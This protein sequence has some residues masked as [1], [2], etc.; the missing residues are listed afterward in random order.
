MKKFF[1]TLTVV[2]LLA[3]GVSLF[4]YL[5]AKEKKPPVV[6]ETVEPFIT[7]IVKKTVA[8][9]SIKPRKEVEI[10]P[11]VPGILQEVYVEPGQMVKKDDPIAKVQIIPEMKELNAAEARLVQAKIKYDH[12]KWNIGQQKETFKEG[13]TTEQ[14]Y[15]RS[16]AEYKNAKAEYEAAE[17]NLEII[18]RG[19]AKNTTTTNTLICSTMDGM[20]LDVPVEKGDTVIQSNSFNAGSTIATVADMNDLIFEGKLDESE[21]GKIKIGMK[22]LISIGAIDNVEF[23]ATLEHI[24]P[25]GVEENGAILFPVRADVDLVD[26]IFVRAGYSATANIVLDKKEHVL[27]VNESVLQFDKD[28]KTFVEVEIAPQQYEKRYIETGISDSI[29]IEVI[30]GI[31]KDIKLK[32]PKV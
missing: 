15:H 30:S 27:A 4:V 7:D 22:L 9:G 5:A 13:I 3:G 28:N 21:V 2:I 19:V 32:V 6:F 1:I 16:E 14:D 25:K 10:K 17:N 20:I 18:K 12:E 11:Q 26:N 24:S 23:N 8:T 31:D 29:N